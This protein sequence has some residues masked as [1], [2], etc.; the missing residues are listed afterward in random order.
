M[1]A[2]AL[3]TALA[4]P[5]P[6]TPPWFILHDELNARNGS[7]EALAAMH[8]YRVALYLSPL[9]SPW[10]PQRWASPDLVYVYAARAAHWGRIALEV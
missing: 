9:D 8:G 5:Q 4:A 1:N 2:P 6:L 7:P 3:E 10:T